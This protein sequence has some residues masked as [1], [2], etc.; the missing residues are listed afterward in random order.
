[1][2]ILL[3]EDDASIGKSVEKGLSEAGHAC[4]WVTEGKGGF[5]QAMTQ[6]FDAVVLDLLLPGMPGVEVHAKMRGAGV[7]TPVIVLT[8]LGSVDNRVTGLKEGADDYLVKPFHLAELL[9]RI[10]A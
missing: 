6:R 10:E 9:A 1:M 8:A 4:R 2:E 5:D 7:N 3:I